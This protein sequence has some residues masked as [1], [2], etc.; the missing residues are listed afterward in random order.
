MTPPARRL[1]SATPCLSCDR[2]IE[3]DERA[4]IEHGIGAWHEDCDPPLNLRLYRRER[5]ARHPTRPPRVALDD[6]DFDD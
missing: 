6:L 5:D 1:G 3:A 2:P 4:Y